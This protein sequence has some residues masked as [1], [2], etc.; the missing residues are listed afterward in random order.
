MFIELWAKQSTTHLNHTFDSKIHIFIELCAKQSTKP[1]QPHIWFK[2]MYLH[3]AFCKTVF[4][5]FWTSF[6]EKF[7]VLENSKVQRI[8]S[9]I[10]LSQKKR[11]GQKVGDRYWESLG[12]GT[13][14]TINSFFKK[15]SI[16]IDSLVNISLPVYFT[17][18]HII[19]KKISSFVAF[20]IIKIR[21]LL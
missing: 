17:L 5:T 9:P 3:R 8:L 14:M 2:E 13:W 6:F 15:N 20:W 7:Q 4:K 11:R 19:R 21:F 10:I 18:A 12:G 1:C 16:A